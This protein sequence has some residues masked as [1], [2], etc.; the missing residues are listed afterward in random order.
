MNDRL[1]YDFHP[2]FLASQRGRR[3]LGIAE[4]LN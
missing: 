3:L 4:L 2:N 1:C